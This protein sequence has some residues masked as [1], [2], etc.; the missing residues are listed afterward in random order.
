VLYYKIQ[1]IYLLQTIAEKLKNSFIIKTLGF[2]AITPHVAAVTI[3]IKQVRHN[4][5]ERKVN[6]NKEIFKNK[7]FIQIKIAATLLHHCSDTLVFF[8]AV[9][10]NR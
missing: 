8:D 3:I 5:T 1:Q 10:L 7:L 6:S 9:S 2:Y 4:N